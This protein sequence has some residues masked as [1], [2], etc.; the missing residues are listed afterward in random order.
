MS[1]LSKARHRVRVR[2]MSFPHQTISK[3][4]SDRPDLA[5]TFA[6]TLP[7]PVADLRASVEAVLGTP[8]GWF[9][10]LIGIRDR[11]VAPFGV[12]TSAMLRQELETADRIDFF[13]VLHAGPDEVMLGARDRHLDFRIAFRRVRARQGELIAATTEVWCHNTLG[14]VYLALIRPA[15]RIVVRSMLSRMARQNLQ[16]GSVDSPSLRSRA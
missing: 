10:V 11:I 4:H 9:R 14:R 16:D 6:V 3:R 5:D 8:P 2:E 15:H 12:A 13:P 7:R 1:S